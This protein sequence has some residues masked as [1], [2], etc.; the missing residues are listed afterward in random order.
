MFVISQYGG[1]YDQLYNEVIKPICER[2]NI[3]L[4]RADEETGATP[5]LT[6]IINSIRTAN[7]IIADITPDNPNVFMS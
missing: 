3:R 2:K 6:D 1:I 5:I 7:I 4:K